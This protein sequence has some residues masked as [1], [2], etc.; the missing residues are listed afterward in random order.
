MKP[1][2]VFHINK[3]GQNMSSFYFG[4]TNFHDFFFFF[5]LLFYLQVFLVHFS[6]VPV[7]PGPMRL[8]QLA[9]ADTSFGAQIGRGK[10]PAS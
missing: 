2:D 6:V 9:V 10:I 5:F 8:S 1:C 7:K 3:D 4:E